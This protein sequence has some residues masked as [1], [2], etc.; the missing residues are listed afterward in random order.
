MVNDCVF[1]LV[2]GGGM[3][4]NKLGLLLALAALAVAALVATLP[5]QAFPASAHEARNSSGCGAA[6]GRPGELQLSRNHVWPGN[7]ITL[8]GHGFPAQ[9]P[10]QVTK[11]GPF[12]GPSFDQWV[13]SSVPEA[14]TDDRG[15]FK[16]DIIIPGLD[17]GQHS[18][19]VKVAEKRARA[20][21]A[22]MPSVTYPS[23]TPL[24]RAV[25]DLGD[26][27]V[28]AFYFDSGRKIWHFYD[29]DLPES[30]LTLLVTGEPYWI[31]VRESAEVI[32]NRETRNLS[33]N[34]EGN[35]WN[36]IVW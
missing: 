35:C 28:R 13:A 32:L 5:V 36:L 30:D 34:S 11:M 22:L 18:I 15:C 33:C 19:E 20:E 10:V 9:T 1:L 12:I 21:F 4:K 14:A 31:L 6:T 16:F 2:Y 23:G 25:A 3:P 7:T 8:G 26:N 24:P 17:V 27:F 29:P